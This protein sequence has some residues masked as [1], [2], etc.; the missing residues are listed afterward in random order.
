MTCNVQCVITGRIKMELL[1]AVIFIV[2]GAQA[3]FVIDNIGYILYAV[4]GETQERSKM[5]VISRFNGITIKMYFHQSEH[6]PPHIHAI[7]GEY[8]GMFSLEDGNMFE[9]DISSKIQALVTEF[10][11]YYR[12]DLLMMWKTQYFKVLPPI[13]K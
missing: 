5:P 10:I 4:N 3:K 2:G 6:N 1:F 11:L 9:G 8:V 12:E 13:E 7:Y